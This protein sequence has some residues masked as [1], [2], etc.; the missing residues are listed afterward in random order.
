[1]NNLNH[2]A[3]IMDGNNRWAKNTN[4]TSSFTGHTEG[5]KQARTIIEYCA[6]IKLNYLSLFVFSTENWSRPKTEITFLMKLLDNSVQK[7]LPLLIKNNIQLHLIGDLAPL[8]KKTKDSLLAVVKK[9]KQCTGLRLILAINYGGRLDI[10]QACQSYIKEQVSKIIEKDNGSLSKK[11][12]TISDNLNEKK[13]NNF[14]YSSIAPDPDLIIRTSGETRLSNFYLW[15]SAYSEI[16]WTDKLW[17]D[18]QPKDLQNCINDF[19]NKQRRFG[20]RA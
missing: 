15:S 20:S 9:S 17:P 11:L 3:I 2:I 5:L 1:M 19:K 13:L 8:P 4:S 12:L 7:E 14:M 16:M 6:K 10:T 18:F